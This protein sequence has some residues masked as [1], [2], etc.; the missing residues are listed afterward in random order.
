M[1]ENSTIIFNDIQKVIE[2]VDKF[3]EYDAIQFYNLFLDRQNEIQKK[4]NPWIP[5]KEAAEMLGIKVRCLRGKR[6]THNIRDTCP[7]KIVH[8]HIDDLIAYFDNAE[9]IDI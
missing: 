7:G 9:K 6:D 5:E 1:N 8:Y 4:K 3:R 2:L